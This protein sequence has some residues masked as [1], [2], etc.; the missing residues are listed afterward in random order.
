MT[1][2]DFVRDIL[3][4]KMNVK[5]LVIGYDHQFGKNR[6]GSIDFLRSIS[7][8]YGFE[9]IEIEA[10][11]VDD[12]NVSSTKVRN[13]ILE[14]DI[15]QANRYLGEPYELSGKVIKGN[16]LGTELGFPTA[17]LD[18][19]SDTKLLPANGVYAVEAMLP[20]GSNH[21]GMMNIG[22]K[23][24]VKDNDELSIEINLFDFDQE[25][26]GQYLTVRLL[27]RVRSEFKFDSLE[28]LKQQIVKDEGPVRSYFSTVS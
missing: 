11:E 5:R 10:Q 14:G 17:N 26:Y 16:R 7:D 25:I 1:A 20:D 28:E 13:A 18:I 3:V 23:P 21:R 19:E 6:E 4:N 12:V 2:L 24:T 9:V 27:S 8:T 15:E 22:K